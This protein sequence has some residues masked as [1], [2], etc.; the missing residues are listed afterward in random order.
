MIFPPKYKVIS[1]VPFEGFGRIMGGAKGLSEVQEGCNRNGNGK[2]QTKVKEDSKSL[3]K[4]NLVPK[5]L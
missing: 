2:V 3:Q 1:L 5:F 4:S